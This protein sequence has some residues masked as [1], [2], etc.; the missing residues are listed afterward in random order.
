MNYRLSSKETGE[1][2][3]S[4]GTALKRLLP[5]ITLEKGKIAIAFLAILVTSAATLTSPFIIGQTVDRFIAH[6]DYS[7]V[8][9]NGAILLAIYVVALFTSYIQT[10]TMGGV[11]RRILFNLRNALFTKLQELPVAFFNQN[12]S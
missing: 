11:G 8:V 12:K 2:R 10:R 9:A 3:E 7:G 5:L 1:K 6:G 4:L